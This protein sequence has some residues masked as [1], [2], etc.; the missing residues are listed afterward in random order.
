MKSKKTACNH[1][2]LDNRQC[3]LTLRGE[4]RVWLR[5]HVTDTSE[6]LTV[7]GEVQAFAF[8]RI[9][10]SRARAKE[11]TRAAMLI[12]EGGDV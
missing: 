9:E 7:L 11:L 5:R 2:E 4:I 8:E 3:T 1:D 6:A 12:A 10:E